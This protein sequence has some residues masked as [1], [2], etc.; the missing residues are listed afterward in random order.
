M[1]LMFRVTTGAMVVC[2]VEP[3]LERAAQYADAAN[4]SLGTAAAMESS[5]GVDMASTFSSQLYS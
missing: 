4:S 5:D 1:S 3:E 2:D